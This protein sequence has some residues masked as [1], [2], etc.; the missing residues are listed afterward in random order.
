MLP[1]KSF[2]FGMKLWSRLEIFEN[3]HALMYLVVGGVVRKSRDFFSVGK[4]N[5]RQ[6]ERGSV[7]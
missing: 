5:E 4:F 3:L 6:E 1:V 7:Q 2:F